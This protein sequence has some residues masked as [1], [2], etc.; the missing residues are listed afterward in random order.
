MVARTKALT[1]DGGVPS[2]T[3]GGVYKLVLSYQTAL[4]FET[5]A[6]ALRVTAVTNSLDQPSRHRQSARLARAREHRDNPALRS[7]LNA[8]GR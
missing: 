7:L 8:A 2:C 6:Y 4:G 5:G 3:T 1:N